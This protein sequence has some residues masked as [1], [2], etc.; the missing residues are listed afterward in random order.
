M[1]RHPPS[2]GHTAD[3]GR[4]GGG[5]RWLLHVGTKAV[6]GWTRQLHCRAPPV[7]VCVQGAQGQEWS[8]TH[9]ATKNAEGC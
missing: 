5:A 4:Q 3:T 1:S 2:A 7:G 6:S 8:Q 9:V